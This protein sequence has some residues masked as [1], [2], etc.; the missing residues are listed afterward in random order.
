M[1]TKLTQFT[2]RG[3]IRWGWSLLALLAAS[4]FPFY[5]QYGQK[6]LVSPGEKVPPELVLGQGGAAGK[7]LATLIGKGP[8]L[9][10]Y[11]RPGDQVSEQA[12]ANAV[13]MARESAPTVPL[14]LVG[15]LAASQSPEEFNSRLGVLG[16][17]GI[18]VHQDGGQLAFVLGVRKVPSFALIDAGGV[19]RLVGGSDLAQAGE[20]GVTALEALTL[21]GRGQPVPTVGT[22]AT[23]RVYRWL[24]KPLPE[25]AATNPDG[26]TWRKLSEVVARG[27]RTL[28]FY[29]SPACAHCK[30]MLPK[31]WMWYETKRPK[32]LDIVTLARADI[33]ALRAEIAPL[34]KAFT[35]TNLLDLDASIT[36]TLM[37]Q[38]TPT[39][40]LVGSDGKIAGIQVGAKINWEK[41][42]ASPAPGKKN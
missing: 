39:A 33:P 25:L 30:E 34:I 21:A 5:A 2:C 18:P 42:L 15:I 4:S 3:G 41:W 9:V 32:D 22:L 1:K 12:L 7:D 16:L 23:D 27:R 17:A 13:G 35:W 6:P 37:V 8:V 40:F 24:G 14:Y 28:L 26:R 38:E 19:L 31:L 20:S 11:W 29:W 36:K 10:I